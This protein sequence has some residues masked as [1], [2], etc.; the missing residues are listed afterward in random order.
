MVDEISYRTEPTRETDGL[1]PVGR[2]RIDASLLISKRERGLIFGFVIFLPQFFLRQGLTVTNSL[3]Y[4][5]V[6]AIASLVGVLL[7]HPWP[8]P[9]HHRRLDFH[10]RAELGSQKID[11][12]YLLRQQQRA[13]SSRSAR[14]ARSTSAGNPRELSK[15]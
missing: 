3:A 13:P 4:T 14:R 11:L 10:H 8:A 6:L 5:M 12:R 15:G 1:D 7:G 2:D 9:E